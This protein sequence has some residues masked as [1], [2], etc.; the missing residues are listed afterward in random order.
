M[1]AVQLQS[2]AEPA[3]QWA[4]PPRARAPPMNALLQVSRA[5]SAVTS[6]AKFHAAAPRRQRPRMAPRGAGCVG[7]IGQ[8]CVNVTAFRQNGLYAPTVTAGIVRGLQ[9]G[10]PEDRQG[11]SASHCHCEGL[12]IVHPSTH[13]HTATLSRTRFGVIL[14]GGTPTKFSP[15]LRCRIAPFVA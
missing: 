5:A 2:P 10:A 13:C 11:S 7:G 1:Q 9:C 14:S 15:L 12:I 3:R 8:H 6:P 4:R